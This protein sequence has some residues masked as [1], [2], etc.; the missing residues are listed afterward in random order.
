MP[1]GW[2]I[3]VYRQS[4]GGGAPATFRADHGPRLAVWQSGTRGLHWLH[5]LV[6]E[7][8]AVDLGGNG[9]PTEYTAMASQIIPT[10]RHGPPDARDVWVKG[11]GDITNFAWLGETTLD[12]TAIEA[13]SPTEWLLVQAWDES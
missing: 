5:A 10:L 7:G 6:A 3:S 2:H 12:F 11:A 8:R 9:Y 4:N 1:V 13:C